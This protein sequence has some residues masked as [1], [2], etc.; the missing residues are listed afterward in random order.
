MRADEQVIAKLRAQEAALRAR[1]VEHLMLFGSR[2]RGTQNSGS[3]ID[4]MVDIAPD[5][6][7]DIYAYVGLKNFIAGLFD[8]PVDV[9]ARAFLKPHVRGTAEADAVHVF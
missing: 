6:V 4:V 1:G 5:A 9:V 7:K 8:E 3:D 2:A